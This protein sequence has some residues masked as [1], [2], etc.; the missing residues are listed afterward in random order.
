MA[1]KKKKGM[2][3]PYVWLRRNGYNRLNVCMSRYPKLFAHIDQEILLKSTGEYVK[4]AED[5]EKQY[6]KLPSSKWLKENG[7]INL[8]SCKIRHPER[9]AH[10]YQEYNGGMNA[11]E[12]V[13]IAENLEKQYDIL[14]SSKWLK[15]NGYVN[16]ATYKAKFPKLFAHI[17]QEKLVKTLDEWVKIA[18]D[19]AKNNNGKLQ[20]PR[21]IQKKYS[22]LYKN[23]LLHS[24]KFWHI[25]QEKLQRILGEWVK[26]AEEMEDRYGKLPNSSW[27]QKNGFDSLYNC[28][29]RHP[30]R[31]SHIKQFTCKEFKKVLSIG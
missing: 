31:F 9:F 10:I 20:N 4:I 14:P 26:I 6:G 12:Y 11:D 5:L 27:L 19:L 25:K 3:P 29:R 17:E 28:K 23:L 22:G 7:H 24:E 15:E 8:A 1:K 16:L 30:E 2:I 13:K 18:E 21:W